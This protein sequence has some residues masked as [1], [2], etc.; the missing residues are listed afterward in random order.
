M[1]LSECLQHFLHIFYF[2][3]D[4]SRDTTARTLMWVAAERIIDI[5]SQGLISVPDPKYWQFLSLTDA[6]GPPD[7]LQSL[8]N[9]YWHTDPHLFSLKEW[10]LL[11]DS[12]HYFLC[13]FSQRLA[14]IICLSQSVTGFLCMS[15]FRM[16]ETSMWWK[17]KHFALC[18]RGHSKAVIFSTAVI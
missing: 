4:M 15:V 12:F 17:N 13:E 6:V 7:F 9:S 1:Q 14:G 11:T 5:S 2:I 8:W 18:N 16:A 3:A 10:T